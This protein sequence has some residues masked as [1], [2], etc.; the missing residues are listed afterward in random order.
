MKFRHRR[1]LRLAK[2]GLAIIAAVQEAVLACDH[3]PGST[4]MIQ[5]KPRKIIDRTARAK[6]KAAWTKPR[7]QQLRQPEEEAPVG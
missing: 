6:P 7:T 4:I 5:R 2:G 1:K 3:A